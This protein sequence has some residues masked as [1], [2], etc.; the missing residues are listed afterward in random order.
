MYDNMY[1]PQWSDR[2]RSCLLTYLIPRGRVRW[3]LY[4][5]A[6]SRIRK[7][8]MAMLVDFLLI[9]ILTVSGSVEAL[10]R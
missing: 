7:C 3:C 10:E 1:D 5:R 8:I 9:R 2:V 6:D 4:A